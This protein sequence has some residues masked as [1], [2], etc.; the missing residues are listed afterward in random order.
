MFY[1]KLQNTQ[2]IVFRV[3]Q[4]IDKNRLVNNLV[5]SIVL[6]CLETL[7]EHEPRVNEI[8]SQSTI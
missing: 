6:A 8:T 7:V 2:F 5:K 3:S 1:E 4:I